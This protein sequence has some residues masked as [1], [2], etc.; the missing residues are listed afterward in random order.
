MSGLPVFTF[1]DSA[2]KSSPC[3]TL[4]FPL[5]SYVLH[6]IFRRGRPGEGAGEY[7]TIRSRPGR[8]KVHRSARSSENTS[9]CLSPD[10]LCLVSVPS[11]PPYPLILSYE[12]SQAVGLWKRAS[13]P[14]ALPRRL[15]QASFDYYLN[16][17]K[18]AVSEW[19]TTAPPPPIRPPLI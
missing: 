5:H 4:S 16:Q 2:S 9:A 17:F 12:M 7:W 1:N 11:H 18:V 15:D 19:S 14:K 3:F 10:L 6:T 13:C 8:G